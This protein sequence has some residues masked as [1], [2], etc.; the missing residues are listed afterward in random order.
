MS[1]HKIT[2]GPA[3]PEVISMNK[4]T[5]G[6]YGVTEAGIYVLK[7]HNGYAVRLKNGD[8]YGEDCILPVTIVPSGTIISIEVS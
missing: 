8:F 5:Q 7:M 4:M 2:M 3:L 6:Q 1:N